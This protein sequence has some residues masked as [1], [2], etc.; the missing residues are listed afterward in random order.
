MTDDQV[1]K[2]AAKIIATRFKTGIKLND[3]NEVKKYLSYK[4]ATYEQEVFAVML[5]DSKYC[6]LKY[7]EVSYGTIDAASV[8]PR[9][10]AKLALRENAAAVILAHNHPSGSNEPSQADKRITQRLVDALALLDIRV[11]DHIIIGET[12]LSFAEQGLV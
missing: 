3:P 11:L 12:A 5:L 7:E 9:E 10:I 6:L 4:L 8:Y 1:L 2:R